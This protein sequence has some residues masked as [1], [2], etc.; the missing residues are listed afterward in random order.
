MTALI[1]DLDGTLLDSY[2]IIVPCVLET[3][4]ESGVE[5]QRDGVYRRLIATS[6][7][8][9][10]TEVG[11]E[12]GLGPERLWARYQ[13][14]STARDGE[15]TLMP[16]AAEA[17]RALQL[18]GVRNFVYTHKGPTAAPVLDRLGIGRYFDYILT[19]GAG[20]P[21]KPAPDGI[22]WIV[23]RFDLD[24]RRTF[25]IGDRRIDV[26]CAENSGIRCVLYLPETSVGA[27]TG[28]EWRVARDLREIPDMIFP[29]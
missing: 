22:E 21:R 5:V 23:R 15:V 27:P 9:F 11:T 8:S 10:F 7:K 16:G 6:V 4:R 25:Y 19:A 12:R 18:L 29:E 17:L 2:K 28:R 1:W 24:K 3:L 14:L 20:L 26:Q 13:E